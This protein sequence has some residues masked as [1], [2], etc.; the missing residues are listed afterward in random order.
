MANVFV[1][2]VTY[3]GSK[4]Y[5]KC[6]NSLRQSTIPVQVV[7]VDNASND[8]TV[9]YIKEHY[10]EI[11]LI[12]S[13]VNLGFGKA[14]NLA[15]RYA[16]DHGCDYVFLLNQDA[17]IDTGTIEKLV[18]IH[19]EH[20]YYGILSPM[21]LNAEKNGVEKGLVTYL[22]NH[23]IT[24]S[25][26]FVDLYFDRVKD[27]YDT[28]YVN[29]AAWLLP[30]KTLLSIGGFDPIFMQYGEDDN[31]IHRVLYHQQKIGICPKCVVVHDTVRRVVGTTKTVQTKDK[32]LLAELTDIRK[33]LDMPV[34]GVI[35]KVRE[36]DLTPSKS[37]SNSPNGPNPESDMQTI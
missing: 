19:Q 7:V 26:L 15:M 4:W 8:G 32:V 1:V 5:D 36:S 30:R 16:L 24:N 3:K 22:D 2:I 21:H 6:F 33:K 9:E 13:D 28:L 10:P 14:N 37:G 27:V 17:W 11:Y 12:E 34:L 35:P 18:A 23:K 25:D 20:G 31:Y 29:A